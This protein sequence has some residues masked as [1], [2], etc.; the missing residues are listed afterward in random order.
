MPRSSVFTLREK[1]VSVLV[2]VKSALEI[3]A[4]L[5]STMVP[6]S[7]VVEDCGQVGEPG[8]KT[9]IETDITTTYLPMLMERHRQFS[10]EDQK[11]SIIQRLEYSLPTLIA[12]WRPSGDS[13]PQQ[14]SLPQFHATF[15]SPCR[16]T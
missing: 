3:P 10:N 6:R 12:N 14:S 7:D 11:F 13:F 2:S 9:M 16:F 4:P 15:V 8:A 5:G 1:P